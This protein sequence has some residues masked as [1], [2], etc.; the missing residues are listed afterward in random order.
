MKQRVAIARALY[1]DSDLLLMDEPF[2]GLDEALRKQIMVLV[3]HERRKPGKLTLLVTHDRDE[4]LALADSILHFSNAP[5][6]DYTWE[7]ISQ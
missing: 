2:R 1:C 7:Q 4:A 3:R 6:S 5:A